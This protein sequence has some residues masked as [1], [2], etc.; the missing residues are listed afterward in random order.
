M[1][2]QQPD[3]GEIYTL[4]PGCSLVWRFRISPRLFG[5]LAKPAK[6]GRRYRRFYG[7]V[8]GNFQCGVW[9]WKIEQYP[10]DV[11]DKLPDDPCWPW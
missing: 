7:V 1:T 11:A 8:V 10:P 4:F 2:D 6:E 3:N 9:G 5:L